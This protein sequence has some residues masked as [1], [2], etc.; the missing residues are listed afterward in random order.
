M[1]TTGVFVVLQPPLRLSPI[2]PGKGCEGCTEP[3]PLLQLASGIA[4]C[5]L[6]CATRC[7]CCK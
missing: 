3:S 6:S 4:Q 2:W 1:R 7:P 5:R